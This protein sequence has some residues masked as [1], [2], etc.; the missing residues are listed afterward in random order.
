VSSTSSRHAPCD[1]CEQDRFTV[2]SQFDRRG[3]PLTTVAC[4]SCGLI[5]HENVPTNAELADYYREHYRA[6]YH[7]EF[8]PS[9]YRVVREWNRGQELLRLLNSYLRPQEAVFE[10]GSGIGC[11]VKSFEC[12]GYE[13][14]GVEP[15]D[16]F[17]SFATNQ[18][19]ATVV[20]GV[21]SDLPAEPL[22]DMALLVHVLEHL[23]SPTMALQHIRRLLRPGGRLYIEVPNA[24]APHAAPGKMFH[25]AHIYNFT[26][27]TL[28]M[29]AHKARFR[30]RTWLSPKYDRNIRVLLE[31]TESPEWQVDPVSYDA[32]LEVLN[33]YST[34]SYHMRWEYVQV[35][36]QTVL[37]HASDRVRAK[38]RMKRIVER[39]RQHMRSD[40][41]LPRAA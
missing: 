20:A 17:R 40:A 37:S 32:T 15:G 35:R 10:I 39:C 27:A 19:G 25:Y 11:T 33:R 7:G 18:L 26:P 38:A 12:A 41:A 8:T 34:L 4:R 30:V 13:A 1:L 23:N 24:A 2:V 14:L 9:A 31:P 16:G 28:Q 21:L 22:G 3:G 29:L 5:S 36:L 6:D